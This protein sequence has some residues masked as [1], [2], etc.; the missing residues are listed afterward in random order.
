MKKFISIIF[1]LSFCNINFQNLASAAKANKADKSKISK[2]EEIVEF[3]P[4][5]K[6]VRSHMPI[7][8]RKIYL[9]KTH[10]SEIV[11]LIGKPM[12][13]DGSEWSYG[14][15][16]SKIDTAL[17]FRNGI[18]IGVSYI[19]P[20]TSFTLSEIESLG[21]NGVD[22]GDPAFKSKNIKEI[23]KEREIYY[24]DESIT[25]RYKKDS[26]NVLSVVLLG[27]N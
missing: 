18:V 7:K 24:P 20:K 13:K 23:G 4:I 9:Q 15:N 25:I 21:A 5:E 22:S 1:V 19:F 16:G 10:E 27:K 6:I 2:K 11:K 3:K 12:K 17:K 26:K 8:L 14:F